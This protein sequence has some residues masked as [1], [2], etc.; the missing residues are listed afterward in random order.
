[1]FR[2]ANTLL[3]TNW[4]MHDLRHTAALRMSRD[5]TLSMRDVQTIL[6]NS[7]L[8]TTADV[9]LVEEE[10]QVIKRVAE[11]L[12]EREARPTAPPAA[13]LLGYDA[14][15]LNVLLGGAQ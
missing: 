6:G 11:H 14:S 5:K 9:Y 8:S 15:D 1:V 2:R 4:S 13:P 12:A 3:G 10:A 7:H